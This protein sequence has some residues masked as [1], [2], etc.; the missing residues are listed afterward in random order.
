MALKHI[1]TA[2]NVKEGCFFFFFFWLIVY[3][4]DQVLE[5]KHKGGGVPIGQ[6]ASYAK[7]HD[8]QK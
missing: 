6:K 5:N 1:Y 4:R 8:N 3:K 2:L 7:K